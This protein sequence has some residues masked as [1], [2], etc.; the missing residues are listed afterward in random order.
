MKCNSPVY[1][2]S[3]RMQLTLI[4]I[5]PHLEY[6]SVAIFERL[7]TVFNGETAS[8]WTNSSLIFLL[9]IPIN[10]GLSKIKHHV[11]IIYIYIYIYISVFLICSYDAPL[12]QRASYLALHG[13]LFETVAQLIMIIIILSLTA[14]TLC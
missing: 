11:F 5:M 14:L 3:Q 13:S 9:Y 6:I 8:I 7:S 2:E 1:H 10:T 12:A 4:A